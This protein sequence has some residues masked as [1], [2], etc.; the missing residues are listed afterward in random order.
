MK[1]VLLSM[2]AVFS[3]VVVGCSNMGTEPIESSPLFATYNPYGNGTQ[4]D[5][6]GDRNSEKRDSVRKQPRP[7]IFGDLLQ[8]LNLTREQKPTVER[9]LTEHRNCVES[10]VKELKDAERQ[11]LMNGRVE[12]DKIKTKVKNGEITREQ[13]RQELRKLR[14]SVNTRLKELPKDKV[15]ECIKSCDDRFIANLREILTSEQ[16]I[17]LE[18]WLVSRSKRGTTNDKKP[19]GRG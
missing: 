14:E 17:I 7:T 3:L 6:V 2:F 1:T 18:K 15:R 12:E 5:E 10:C 16:R 9:F 11:I 8:R 19:E 4:S 13:A